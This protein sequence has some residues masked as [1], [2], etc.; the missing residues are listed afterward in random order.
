[1]MLGDLLASRA[2]N[3]VRVEFTNQRIETRRIV[4]I[5]A[6]KL[7]ERIQAF[8]CASAD[9]FVSIN[10]AH[11]VDDSKTG[12]FRQGDTYQFIPSAVVWG[13]LRSMGSFVP[14]KI[15]SAER[16]GRPISGEP[17]E[18]GISWRLTIAYA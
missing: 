15:I 16:G 8:G 2:M 12:Y 13:Q 10:L 17:G 11:A 4:W 7:H 1:M 3:A 9:W 14:T 6:L 18:Y 5:L